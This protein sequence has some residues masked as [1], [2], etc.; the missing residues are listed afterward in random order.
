MLRLLLNIWQSREYSAHESSIQ[1]RTG[2][3]RSQ[4]GTSD[5]AHEAVEQALRELESSIQGLEQALVSAEK[6]KESIAHT[7]RNYQ[8][9]SETL[10][11]EA[12]VAMQTS[13]E[14][15]AREILHEQQGVEGMV[16][17]Y[18]R[19]LGNISTTLRKMHG[20]HRSM[21]IQRDEIKAQRAIIE[22]QLRSAQSHEEFMKNLHALGLSHERLEEELSRTHIRSGLGGNDN[23]AKADEYTLA[24]ELEQA[25]A[26]SSAEDILAAL[27]AELEAERL[28]KSRLE[29]EAVQKR[30]ALAFEG[31]KDNSSKNTPNAAS[32]LAQRTLPQNTPT[33][34]KKLADFFGKDTA[35]SPQPS[36][37]TPSKEEY[38]K[39]FFNR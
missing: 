39:N 3:S 36:I 21:L 17:G 23:A 34:Q 12:K 27:N 20:Q 35:V 31:Q 9:H 19:M 10:H 7:L 25:S 30:F 11:S 18:E 4:A 16:Q 14:A 5:T 1:Q 33:P 15:A 22:A 29:V 24:R 26:E 2:T 37:D 28:I 38:V 32:N 13:N 8:Q 6:D